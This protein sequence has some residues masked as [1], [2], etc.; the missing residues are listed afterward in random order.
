[1][2]DDDVK[3]KTDEELRRN[4]LTCDYRGVVYKGLCL[5]ELLRRER[6]KA[7]GKDGV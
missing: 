2:S 3:D 4:L 1:M 7:N 6:D 5:E